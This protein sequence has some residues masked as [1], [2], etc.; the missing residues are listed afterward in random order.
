MAKISAYRLKR[1]SS[2]RKNRI[3]LTSK[4]DAKH[5]NIKNSLHIDLIPQARPTCECDNSHFFLWPMSGRVTFTC[6]QILLTE[7]FT[8]TNQKRKLQE[9]VGVCRCI[10]RC[11]RAV[12]FKVFCPDNLV[13]WPISAADMSRGMRLADVAPLTS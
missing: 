9:H 4:N 2:Y 13:R 10:R 1:V 11:I 3:R 7:K 5:R 8:F 12:E 6:R